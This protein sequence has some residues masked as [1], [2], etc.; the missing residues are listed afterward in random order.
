M[1]NS[2]TG[3]STVESS[4]VNKKMYKQQHIGSSRQNIGVLKGKAASYFGFKKSKKSESPEPLRGQEQGEKDR[5]VGE[6]KAIYTSKEYGKC[7]QEGVGLLRGQPKLAKNTSLLFYLAMSHFKL[8]Q[9]KEARKHFEEIIALDP[10]YKKSVYLFLAISLKKEEQYDQ[11]IEVLG[12]CGELYPNFSEAKV[13]LPYPDIHGPHLHQEKAF[14]RG[15]WSIRAVAVPGLT[16]QG[17]CIHG[18]R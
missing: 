9:H 15:H 7:V 4:S 10:A 17:P 3:E 5:Q 16:Q 1:E 13:F 6:L 14:P 2:I 8:E 12:K 11:A 18:P